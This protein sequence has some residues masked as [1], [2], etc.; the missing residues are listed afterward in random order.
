[1]EY[2]GNSVKFW[3]KIFIKE[4]IPG[5]DAIGEGKFHMFD[6]SIDMVQAAM[7]LDQLES[8]HPISDPS[9]QTIPEINAN[10][11][12]IAYQKVIKFLKRS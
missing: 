12:N 10:F 2:I 6:Q 3:F 11:D 8:S 4:K 1:M 5:T 9:F 7:D